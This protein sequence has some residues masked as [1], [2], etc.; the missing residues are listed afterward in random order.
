M[1]NKKRYEFKEQRIVM[2]G[3]VRPGVRETCVKVICNCQKNKQSCSTVRVEHVKKRGL[4]LTRLG[5]F[6]GLKR[7]TLSFT[8]TIIL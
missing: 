1:S 4:D 7:E 2:I 3:S 6:S 5:S 8:F